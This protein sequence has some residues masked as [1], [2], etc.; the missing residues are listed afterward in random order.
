MVP[1]LIVLEPVGESVLLG[2]FVSW[3]AMTLFDVSPLGF[4]M[5]HFLVWF[6]SDY[7]LFR[8]VEV[9]ITFYFDFFLSATFLGCLIRLG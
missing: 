3:A 5:G 9:S 8:I 7:I 6:L 2:V 4:F 1:T